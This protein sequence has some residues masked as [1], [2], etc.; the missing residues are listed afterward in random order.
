M[1]DK[2]KIMPMH[3]KIVVK[4]KEGEEK[5]PG[6]ILLP[7]T[8]KD[9]PIE[10]VVIAVG[11]GIRNE[12]GEVIPLDVKVGDKIIFAKWGGTEIEIDGEKLLIIKEN[13]V[14]AKIA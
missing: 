11:S 9:K 3:D 6:G 7:E 10:G 14:L 12:K 1:S 2:N 8:A 4:R 13:D 5:T